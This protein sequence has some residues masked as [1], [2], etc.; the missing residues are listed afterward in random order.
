MEPGC[1]PRSS[2]GGKAISWR[3]AGRRYHRG[4]SSARR[5]EAE[6]ILK[7]CLG[8]PLRSFEIVERQLAVLVLRAQVMLSLSSIV[9][10]DSVVPQT[11][12]P[13][14]SGARIRRIRPS[15]F[16]P[17]QARASLPSTNSIQ[18]RPWIWTRR[19]VR[20]ARA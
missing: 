6:H 3:L 9:I 15:W 14:P 12:P 7:L 17:S 2:G 5:R 13:S 20:A 10:T 4:M 8:D 11:T 1:L 19:F 18:I 16:Q